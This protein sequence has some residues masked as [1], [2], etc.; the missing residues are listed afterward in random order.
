MRTEADLLE[1]GHEAVRRLGCQALLVTR[2]RHGMALFDAK[3]GV[4]L[5]PGARREGGGGR[6]GS[7]G[8]GDR[9]PSRWRWRP[10]RRFGEAARL[11]NVAGALVVQKQGTATVSRDELLGELRSAR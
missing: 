6:D 11:A 1:A 3:G 4:E 8:H 10:G 2:G 5:H 7:G 9:E